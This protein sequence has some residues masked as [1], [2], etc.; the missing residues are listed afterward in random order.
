MDILL[1]G[2]WSTSAVTVATR[3]GYQQD[4]FL[5]VYLFYN[6]FYTVVS[7]NHNNEH[8]H[9]MKDAHYDDL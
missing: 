1:A 9:L 8:S 2:C 5:A 7:D 4:A 6:N 3:A